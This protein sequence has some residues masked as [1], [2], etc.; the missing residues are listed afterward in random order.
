MPFLMEFHSPF[1]EVLNFGGTFPCQ[2]PNRLLVA[3][4]CARSKSVREMQIRR[5]RCSNRRS[6]SSFEH[7]ENSIPGFRSLS[8]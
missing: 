7:N 4:P 8:E 5:I 1:Y 2:N 3:Q 6:D